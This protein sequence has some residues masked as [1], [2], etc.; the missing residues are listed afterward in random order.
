MPGA[1]LYD[2]STNTVRAIQKAKGNTGPG[3][4]LHQQD[5]NKQARGKMMKAGKTNK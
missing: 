2:L 3:R 5:R 1:D 4:V